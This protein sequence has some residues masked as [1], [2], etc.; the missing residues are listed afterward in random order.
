[1]L[2]TLFQQATAFLDQPHQ[3]FKR[4]TALA[5]KIIANVF[6]EPST[7]T[8]NTFE[9]AAKHLGAEVIHFNSEHSSVKKGESLIDTLQ[10]LIA[11]GCHLLVIRHPVSGVLEDIAPQIEPR[12]GVI[13]AGDGT[14]AHPTQALL[15]LFTML[16]VFPDLQD[17][18]IAIIGDVRHSRVAHSNLTLLK[19][20]GVRD[21][22]IIAPDW[23]QLD[24]DHPQATHGFPCTTDLKS[25]I[26]NAHIVYILRLQKERMNQI[27]TQHLSEYPAL[28]EVTPDI[29]KYAHPKA[30]VMHPGPI[31]RGIEIASAVADGAQSM[32]LKQVYY[33]IAIRMA[34]LLLALTPSQPEPPV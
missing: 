27:S 4:S 32:I 25:G 24:P 33:G 29:L 28:F 20:F 14:H 2:D 8:R 16:Q 18:T 6:F 19:T 12:I 11:M 1:M 3:G 30:I 26:H 7:R 23:L 17:K 15:D 34:A 31:N 9:I 10:T 13:N 21:I 5:G 22:R